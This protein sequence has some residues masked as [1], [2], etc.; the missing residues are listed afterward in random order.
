MITASPTV[1]C[2][3]ALVTCACG[4]SAMPAYKGACKI[5]H[6]KLS[7]RAK[8]A[9]LNSGE[10]VTAPATRLAVV[11]RRSVRHISLLPEGRAGCFERPRPP[12]RSGGQPGF[13][14]TGLPLR[15]DPVAHVFCAPGTP[16]SRARRACTMPPKRQGA[17]ASRAGTNLAN[18][19]PLG[20]NPAVV[21]PAFDRSD[22]LVRDQA[23]ERKTDVD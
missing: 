1:A 8:I 13:S 3:Q 12:R 14:L 7:S 10:P 18:N 19:L 17:T 5:S 11:P 22:R 9:T 16:R 21:P 20:A 4:R 23:P 15:S 6:A 2:R